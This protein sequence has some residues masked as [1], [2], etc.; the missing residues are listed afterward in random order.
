MRVESSIDEVPP[1]GQG[2]GCRGL[3]KLEQK[4]WGGLRDY[5]QPAKRIS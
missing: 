3:A 4:G 1:A 5:S 2:P